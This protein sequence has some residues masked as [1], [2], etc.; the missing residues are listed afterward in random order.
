MK[1]HTQSVPW[2]DRANT[3]GDVVVDTPTTV[4]KRYR[5]MRGNARPVEC[6]PSSN[7]ELSTSLRVVGVLA[8]CQAIVFL[9][10]FLFLCARAGA[11]TESKPGHSLE[12]IPSTY[13]TQNARDPFGAEVAGATDA[14]GAGTVPS[15][16][17]GTLKLAGILYDAVH[18]SALVNDQLLE[19]N[20]AVK[21]QTA[22]GEV[23]VTAL[24]ITRDLVVLQVGGQKM[25]LRLGGGGE[26]NQEAR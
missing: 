6:H 23:E 3:N 14:K 15:V 10:L 16:D 19:L 24:K 2:I 8:F 4:R 9:V 12:L 11:A 25:E 17:A 20:R 22:Q 5:S 13:V 18:P 7:T 1:A 21:M 26:H